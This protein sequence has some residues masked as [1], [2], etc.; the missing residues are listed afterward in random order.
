MKPLM[1]HSQPHSGHQ[2]RSQALRSLSTIF[3]RRH[4]FG[5]YGAS[6]LIALCT[7]SQESRAEGADAALDDSAVSVVALS[8]YVVSE[9]KETSNIAAAAASLN[10]MPGG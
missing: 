8:K 9:D 4:A 6:A 5:V 3:S 10:Q 7:T 2:P 1:T